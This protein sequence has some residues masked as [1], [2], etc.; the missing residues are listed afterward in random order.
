M[1]YNDLDFSY[2]LDESFD[3]EDEITIAANAPLEDFW[4]EP[5]VELDFS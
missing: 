5:E 4:L 1:D 3:Y 2:I